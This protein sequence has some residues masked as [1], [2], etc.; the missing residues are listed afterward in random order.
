MIN[1]TNDAMAMCHATIIQLS[2]AQAHQKCLRF[3]QEPDKPLA[4]TFD[5]PRKEDEIIKHQ[6]VAVFAVPKRFLEFCSDKTL[7]IDRHGKLTL[8]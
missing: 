6:G 4:L 1:I 5:E 3:E 8:S 2:H 7:D